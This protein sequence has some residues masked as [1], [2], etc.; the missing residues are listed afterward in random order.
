MF[1]AIIGL[2]VCICNRCLSENVTENGTVPDHF[3]TLT[4]LFYDLLVHCS[5]SSLR[6]NCPQLY[7][8]AFAMTRGA[9]S[10]LVRESTC[11]S[12]GN[13][14]L[15]HHQTWLLVTLEHTRQ[16]LTARVH[17][18]LEHHPEGT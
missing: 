18:A 11:P 17:K 1:T 12:S 6:F 5:K 2:F 7:G 10:D 8:Y 16:T 3:I 9:S 13:Y 4:I 15:P 14:A